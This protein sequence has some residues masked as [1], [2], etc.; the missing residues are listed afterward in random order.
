MIVLGEIKGLSRGNLAGD[1]A[2][3]ALAEFDLVGRLRGLRHDR[4]FVA[5]D[6]DTRAVLGADIVALA[7]ALG[8]VVTFPEYLHQ[9]GKG[10]D[11]R[12]VDHPDRLR[13]A[14]PARADLFIGGVGREALLI[15]DSRHDHARNLPQDPLHTPEAPHGE[16][17]GLKAGRVGA[18]QRFA[19]YKVTLRR[20]KGARLSWQRSSRRWQ[21]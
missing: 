4:L 2:I 21:V 20:G 19:V 6:I 17:G 11:L 1:L 5:G 10:H 13:M 3:A 9:P 12:I 18:F 14:G 8:R 16:I 7:H 15:A